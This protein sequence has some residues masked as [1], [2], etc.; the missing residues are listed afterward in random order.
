MRTTIDGAGRVVIPKALRQRLGLGPG[1]QVEIT[2]QHGL[3]E[4]SPAP[5]DVQVE[6]RGYGPV[7][8]PESA[9]PPLTDSDVRAALERGRR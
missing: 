8:M 5:V 1:A 4:L 2:E 9:V 6:E 7:L 3:L